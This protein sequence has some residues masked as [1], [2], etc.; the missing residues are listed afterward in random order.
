MKWEKRYKKIAKVLP[1][2]MVDDLLS[3]RNCGFESIDANTSINNIIELKKLEF[4]TPKEN[5]KSKCHYMHIGKECDVCPGMKVH[6]QKAKNVS[7]AFYLGDIVRNDGKNCTNIKSRVKK[8]LGIVS[9]IMDILNTISF[10][11]RYFEI[12]R[13]LREAELI[14][15]MLTNAEVW[16][17]IKKSEIDELEMVDKLLIRRIFGAPESA[18]IES[19]YLELGVI[20]IGIMIKA[21]RITYLHYLVRLEEKE[22]LSKV[23]KIQW[24][25]PVK[26]DWILQVQQD[27]K[28]FGIVLNL[29]EIK[30]KSPY[31]FE[32]HVKIKSKEF[33]LEQ[34]LK[35]KS[36]HSK[37]ENL[38]YSELKLQK[39]LNNP[40]IT[41]QEAKNLFKF[42]TRVANFQA[43]MKNNPRFSLTCPFCKV[44]PDTQ[45]C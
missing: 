35:L 41:V 37:M 40:L 21:R 28:D 31:T 11:K 20:P 26:D 43:K 16:Y 42:R 33:A 45:Q 7:E 13:T 4:H 44:Q 6:G 17:G 5:K 2:A 14:N 23:F 3:V 29:E 34:L 36:K 15:G 24:K 27:L 1:L 18:C 38:D 22:M 30:G 19:L 8:G 39:Y 12:A 25:Y 10:G 9:R 32:K